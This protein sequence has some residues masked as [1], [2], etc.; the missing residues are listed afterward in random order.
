MFSKTFAWS[1]AMGWHLWRIATLRP[2]F[3]RLSD[4]GSMVGSFIGLFFAAGIL[5]W[6][7]LGPGTAEYQFLPTMLKLVLHLMVVI[8][9]FERRSR[10]SS[11]SAAVLGVSAVFDI[12]VSVAVLLGL[13]ASVMPVH[14]VEHLMEVL[15]MVSMAAN[16]SNESP[17]VRAKGYRLAHMS[18]HH[19][20]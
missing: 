4:S 19:A 14:W 7:I 9:L 6:A 2:A 18:N 8:V 1:A 16:F 10:S 20:T 12:L 3:S 13:R 5:R 17:A 11:L 15:W